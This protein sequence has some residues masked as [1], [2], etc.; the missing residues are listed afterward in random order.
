MT[1][2]GDPSDLAPSFRRLPGLA[3]GAG[4]SAVFVVAVFLINLVVAREDTA[5]PA[6]LREAVYLMPCAVVAVLVVAAADRNIR[7]YGPA[8]ICAAVAFVGAV[9]DRVVLG[10]GLSGAASGWWELEFARNIMDWSWTL[11]LVAISAAWIAGRRRRISVV[12]VCLLAAVLENL[13][14]RTGM[15]T[16]AVMPP[17]SDLDMALLM[18]QVVILPAVVTVVLTCWAAVGVDKILDVRRVRTGQP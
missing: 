4:I 11:M 8:A 12:A 18:V 7:G 1:A 2:F 17:G 10:F 9:V 14:G 16:V 13:I 6:F 5:L 3:V 15:T